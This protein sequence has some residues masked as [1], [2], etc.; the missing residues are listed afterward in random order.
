MLPVLSDLLPEVSASFLKIARYGPPPACSV[1]HLRV[2]Q[3]TKANTREIE[4]LA[5]RVRVLAES[6]CA[7]ISEGDT[8]EGS[9]RRDLEQYIDTFQH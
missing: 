6:L 9:R 5:P 8:K 7:P 4:S 1:R 2:P 3:Q